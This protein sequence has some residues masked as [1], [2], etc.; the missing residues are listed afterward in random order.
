[1]FFL[2][3]L[4]PTSKIVRAILLLITIFFT[5][6]ALAWDCTVNKS[7]YQLTFPALTIQ[8]D[9]TGNQ[10]L[11][12]WVGS[13]LTSIYSCDSAASFGGKN[14]NIQEVSQG[15]A[16]GLTYTDGGISYNILKTSVDGI[17]VILRAQN[18][19]TGSVSSYYQFPLGYWTTPYYNAKFTAYFNIEAKLIKI[20]TISSGTFASTQVGLVRTASSDYQNTYY[21]PVPIY[22][23]GGNINV[24]ACTVDNSVVNVNL[25]T[26][27]KFK[28][29]AVGYTTDPVDIPFTINCLAG[30]KV[31][32]TVSATADTS[33]GLD[34]LIKLSTADG[35]ATGV[36]V[37]VTNKSSIEVKLNQSIAFGTVATAGAF[38]LGLQARYIQT[39][40]E[41]TAGTA[42]TTATITLTYQ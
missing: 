37:R 2:K 15:V 27:K 5:Q 11:T 7:S 39:N 41:V 31:N 19:S 1:M 9:M 25:G 32:I 24:L 28:F 14:F 42:N 30:T 35:S 6:K 38:D 26:F 13:G 34:D 3:R 21:Y 4:N 10:P 33:L 8:R 40:S 23:Q 20:G 12:D 17:G 29:N 36:A 16:T 18:Q 22:I